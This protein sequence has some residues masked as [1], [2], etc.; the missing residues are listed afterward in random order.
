[1]GREVR[2]PD[3]SATPAQID[4]VA[5]HKKER[6]I[7]LQSASTLLTN[8]F[9][10]W[11]KQGDY[12]FRFEADGDHFRIWV[13][14][15]RRP[16]E[17]ELEGR[18][19]GLQWFLSFYLVFLVESKDSHTNC[20]LLLDEPGLS[21]HPI[22]QRDLSDFFDGLAQ[23]N[24]IIYTTHSPFLVDADRLDRVRKVYVAPDGTS[25]ATSD[26]GAGGIP[27]TQSAGYAVHA[28]LGLNIAESLLLGCEPIVVEGPSDQ[29]YLTA[30]KTLLIRNGSIKIGRELVFPPAGGAK[31][32][33]AIASVLGGRNGELPFALL[34]SDEQG[35]KFAESLR[36]S[37]YSD[38][39]HRIQEVGAF[40]KVSRAEVED[41]IPIEVI[42]KAAQRQFR[43]VDT[44]L[45]AIHVM[46]EPIVPQI[47]KWAKQGGA[48]LLK[49]WKVDLAKRVKQMLLDGAEVPN[50]TL[51]IWKSLFENFQPAVK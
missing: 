22:A 44:E 20:I 30:I 7:L 43:E 33:Q 49:G 26:L 32:I 28:A 42:I 23:E 12:R 14:D 48:N 15:D 35:S 5:Q 18:S 24:R 17:V 27:N 9:R 10:H 34:D 41:L 39:P 6:S 2:Q 31:G 25:K 51:E 38:V 11:W 19:T 46:G 36:K 50:E 37:L 16:E 21:L 47:E 3:Q 29:H 45:S 13:A 8:E 40:V 1:L 4:K